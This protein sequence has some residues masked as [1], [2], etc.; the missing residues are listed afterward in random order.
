M[1]ELWY[2]LLLYRW[3]CACTMYN[4]IRLDNNDQYS[5]V[6]IIFCVLSDTNPVWLHQWY[7]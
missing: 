7:N 2:G 5:Y 6:D 1:F 4:N 3:F